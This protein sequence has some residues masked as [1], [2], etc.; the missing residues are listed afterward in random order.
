MRV[1]QSIY[2]VMCILCVHVRTCACVCVWVGVRACVCVWVG[3][4]VCVYVC[5]RVCRR[6]WHWLS[7]LK[8]LRIT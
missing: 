2:S 5:V 6:M 1:Y 7:V 3:V 8:H 4:F